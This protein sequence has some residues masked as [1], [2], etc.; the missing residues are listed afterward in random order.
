M[1]EFNYIDVPDGLF[2]AKLVNQIAMIHECKGRQQ[3]FAEAKPDALERLCEVAKVQST[4]ASNR[5][6]GVFTTDRRLREL[7][8]Q[9]V[10]PRNR[11]E[12][13]IAGY[14]DVLSTIHESYDYIDVQPGV[15]LQL[16]RDLYR[17]TGLFFGGRWKDS[18]NVIAEVDQD[19]NRRVRFRPLPAVAVPEAMEALCGAYN[20][21]VSRSGIDPLVLAAMFT[22]DFICIHPFND[23]NGRMS[24][25]LTLLL[26]Y[27]S[28]YLVG[29]Y[30]SIEH[31]IEQTKATY[32]ESLQASSRGWAEGGNDYG[33]FVRYLLGCIVAA[34]REFE[35]RVEGVSFKRLSKPERIEALFDRKLGKVTKADILAE[36]PDVSKITV[37]RTLSDLLSRG[38]IEKIGGGRSTGYVRR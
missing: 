7:M 35:N 6:E 22:F 34:Y 10:E 11:N 29:K 16:H 21:A 36:L 5:I 38:K 15:I 31:E 28:G 17:H 2:D 24:R 8:R 1:R 23:G 37:E 13:E 9:S 25:L 14:R 27:R 12:E 20:D 33:P 3:L 18:D 4:D 19:G 30:V 26:L 32:Y